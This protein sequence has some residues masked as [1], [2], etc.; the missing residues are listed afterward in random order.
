[1]KGPV[2]L[3]PLSVISH[4]GGAPVETTEHGYVPTTLSIDGLRHSKSASCVLHSIGVGAHITRPK[5]KVGREE[6]IERLGRLGVGDAKSKT[7]QNVDGCW[8][9]AK[10]LGFLDVMFI[11]GLQANLGAC[12]HCVWG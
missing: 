1:M 2:D 4:R 9:F 5:V 10:P 12:G 6:L 11:G 8:A 7:A 3:L